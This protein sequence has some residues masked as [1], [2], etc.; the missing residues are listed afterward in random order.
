MLSHDLGL[1]RQDLHGGAGEE[2]L[3]PGPVAGVFLVEL[4]GDVV[5]GEGYGN[6]RVPS[7]K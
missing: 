1:F 6:G 3:L 2:T 5:I 4:E 7:H